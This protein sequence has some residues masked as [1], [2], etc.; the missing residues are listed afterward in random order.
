MY[1]EKETKGKKNRKKQGNGLGKKYR[2]EDSKQL[3]LVGKKEKKENVIEEK[4]TRRR[5]HKRRKQVQVERRD[6]AKNN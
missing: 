2:V 4:E 6:C 3:R 5:V 1:V